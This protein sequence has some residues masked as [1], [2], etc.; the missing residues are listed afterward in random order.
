MLKINYSLAVKNN[1]NHEDWV[2]IQKNV[3]VF[4]EKQNTKICTL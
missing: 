4:N 2:V 1:N 3:T